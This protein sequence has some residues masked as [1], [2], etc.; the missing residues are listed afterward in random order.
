MGCVAFV[1]PHLTAVNPGVCTCVC[2]HARAH[3]THRLEQC[4]W[5][6]PSGQ[7]FLSVWALGNLYP[8][9]ASDSPLAQ[10]CQSATGSLCG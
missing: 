3:I 2:A 8:Y 5:L 7:V 6:I 9:H 10:V 4:I 1:Q